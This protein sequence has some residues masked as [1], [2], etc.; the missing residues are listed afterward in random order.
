[1]TKENAHLFLPLVEAMAEGKTI[2]QQSLNGNWQDLPTVYFN[3]DFESYRIKPEPRKPL[4]CWVR[5]VDE[6]LINE[7]WSALKSN[8]NNVH[9][10]LFREVIE[11]ENQ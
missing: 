8:P 5:I 3:S 6:T 9:Y 4:E 7:G 11:P 1:M 2:Q 10:R